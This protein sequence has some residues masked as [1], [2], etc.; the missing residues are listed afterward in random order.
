LLQK[1]AGAVMRGFHLV[2]PLALTLAWF[3]ANAAGAE[4]AQPPP[5]ALT[6]LEAMVANLG[7]TVSESPDKQSF[8]ITWSGQ[9]DYGVH[10]NVSKD[11]SLA[12]IYV[13]IVTLTPA[14]LAKL[15][16]TKLLEANDGGD[17]YF[18]MESDENGAERLYANGMIPL[19]GLTLQDLRI[20]LEG[21]ISDLDGSAPLWSSY[22]K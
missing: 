5:A 21:W 13:Q 11:Q 18:S 6:K 17:F 1:A 10:F 2:L 9:Y 7:Y 16:Y 14:Q 3:C 19:A 8:G 12:Y 22:L 15:Q 4:A 20:T